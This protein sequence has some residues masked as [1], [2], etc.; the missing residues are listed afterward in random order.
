[1]V[2]LS[3]LKSLRASSQNPRLPFGIVP[4]RWPF[5]HQSHLEEDGLGVLGEPSFCRL[6]ELDY[7]DE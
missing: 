3:Y 5:D 1:M 6:C 4:V 7:V 2:N